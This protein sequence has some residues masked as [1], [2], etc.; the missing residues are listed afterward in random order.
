M[1]GSCVWPIR[2][3]SV[4]VAAQTQQ[5]MAWKRLRARDYIKRVQYDAVSS[6]KKLWTEFRNL[7]LSCNEN[8]ETG[9]LCVIKFG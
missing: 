4:A 6:K 1:T 7:N 3:N 5:P 9:R 2:I 8:L